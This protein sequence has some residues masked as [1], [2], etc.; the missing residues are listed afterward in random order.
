MHALETISFDL[1]LYISDPTI[2][3]SESENPYSG[4]LSYCSRNNIMLSRVM[5]SLFFG[6]HDSIDY[7]DSAVDSMLTSSN[8]QFN[9][10]D[11]SLL[12]SWFRSD[13]NAH[14]NEPILCVPRLLSCALNVLQQNWTTEDIHALLYEQ[15]V[16]VDVIEYYGVKNRLPADIT[17]VVALSKLFSLDWT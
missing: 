16:I 13:S 10:S 11:F 14:S 7:L 1:P 12:R 8:K 17:G 2:T 5:N 4:F 6:L 9:S 3:E 15:A